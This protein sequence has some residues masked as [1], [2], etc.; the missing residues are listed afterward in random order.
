MWRKAMD[1]EIVKIELTPSGRLSLA[2][3]IKM[4]MLEILQY[5]FYYV[6]DL[7]FELNETWPLEGEILLSQLVVIAH[8][9]KMQ[10]TIGDVNLSPFRGESWQNNVVPSVGD[11][12]EDADGKK[13]KVSQV[14]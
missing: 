7:G 2:N 5:D 10:I 11:I 14:I 4:R 12:I 8:K 13:K 1:G 3:Q 9:L 6:L